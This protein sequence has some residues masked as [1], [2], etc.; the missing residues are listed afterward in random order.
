MVETQVK[1]A[2]VESDPRLMNSLD[3]LDTSCIAKLRRIQP[4][5]FGKGIFS[6]TSKVNLF[7]KEVAWWQHK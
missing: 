6:E 5:E 4:V 2:L 3:A 7:H 1:G